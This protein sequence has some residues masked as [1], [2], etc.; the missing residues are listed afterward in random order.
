MVV[1]EALA[2]RLVSA[3]GVVEV[4][5]HDVSPA[6]C[7]SVFSLLVI[8]YHARVRRACCVCCGVSC[9]G[10]VW[11]CAMVGAQSVASNML[12]GKV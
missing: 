12:L 11:L 3:V 6:V 8:V 5:E 4:H 2:R 1:G 7:V 9:H 10:V